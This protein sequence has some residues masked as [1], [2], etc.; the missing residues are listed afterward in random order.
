MEP[1][2]KGLIGVVGPCAAGKSTL[3][4]RLL[5]RGYQARH[6][7]QEHSYVLGMWRRITNPDVLVFLKVSFPFTVL[8][9]NLNWTVA[10]YNEQ[11]WRLRDAFK[12]ADLIIDTDLLTPQQVEDEVI[13]FL[14]ITYSGLGSAT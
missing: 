8:R 3:T 4:G 13:A 9:K 6:I 5:L 12:N 11:L 2:G 7:A 1:P 10:E 14:K